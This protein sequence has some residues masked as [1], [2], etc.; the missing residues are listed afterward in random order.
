MHIQPFSCTRPQPDRLDALRPFA[1]AAELDAAVAAGE[2]TCDVSR[3]LYLVGH[4]VGGVATY[5]VVCCCS[6]DELGAGVALPEADADVVAAEAHHLGALG[7]H[8]APV[9]ITYPGNIALNYI[10]GAA[11]TSTPLYNLQREGEQLVIWR[12]SRPEA[13]EAICATFE[14]IEGEVA[15][16]AEAAWT[17]REVAG[18]AREQRPDLD[19][20][21][22]ALHPLAVLV[23]REDFERA[24]ADVLPMRG[25]LMHRF[26]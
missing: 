7:A 8:D 23:T 10:L 1:S 26:A 9:T 15:A 25:L 20:R 2:Y 22:A 3:A 19:E 12:V 21:A 14:Q 11:R 6:A 18:R 13:V 5:G 24:K 4:A 17:A 16:Q